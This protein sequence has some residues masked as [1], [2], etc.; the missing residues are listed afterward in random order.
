MDLPAKVMIFRKICKCLVI[1]YYYIRIILGF[2]RNFLISLRIPI[3]FIIF[4]DVLLWMA[5]E[6]SLAK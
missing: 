1:L 6:E 2:A 3:L 5:G 4:A